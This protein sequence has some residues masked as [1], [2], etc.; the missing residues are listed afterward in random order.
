MVSAI[1]LS[2]PPEQLLGISSF[3][4]SAEQSFLPATLGLVEFQPFEAAAMILTDREFMVAGGTMD[5][6]GR[7]ESIPIT[8]I[9]QAYKEKQYPLFTLGKAVE[10]EDGEYIQDPYSTDSQKFQEV[11]KITNLV[12]YV[13]TVVS[14]SARIFSSAFFVKEINH[15]SY[16]ET[17]GQHP[18][19]QNDM[20]TLKDS[21]GNALIRESISTSGGAYSLSGA[22]FVWSD[23]TV[24]AL[25]TIIKIKENF[26]GTNNGVS[27]MTMLARTSTLT[28]LQKNDSIISRI[29][30]DKDIT[31]A[32]SVELDSVLRSFNIYAFPWEDGYRAVS[33]FEETAYNDLVKLLPADKVVLIAGRPGNN[34]LTAINPG[35]NDPYHQN[36][37]GQT[38]TKY[39]FVYAPDIRYQ[40]IN[41]RLGSNPL[42]SSGVLANGVANGIYTFL[43]TIQSDP[44]VS[45]RK[46][47]FTRAMLAACLTGPA[48]RNVLNAT[49]T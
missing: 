15:P 3:N 48:T 42:N 27:E 21:N 16:A 26:Y 35:T 34:I 25:N 38:F 23:P 1:T 45:P 9:V 33:G 17:H 40:D 31:I 37:F 7:G 19:I 41:Q 14:N 10:I 22:D 13:N 32:S 29:N 28:N 24:D 46:K 43:G 4:F 30:T 20:L 44:G 8:R 49:V 11:Q 47:R 12:N 39:R 36:L 18:L 6:I 2:N 5:V